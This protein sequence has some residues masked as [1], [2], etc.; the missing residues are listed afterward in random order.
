MYVRILEL[1]HA[2][3]LLALNTTRIIRVTFDLLLPAG[4]A[5]YGKS[6][7]WF[8]GFGDTPMRI[9]H[10]SIYDRLAVGSIVIEI[11]HSLS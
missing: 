11:A 2:P 9:Y 3:K 10:L 1:A 4:D 6:L 7:S 5:R 8:S